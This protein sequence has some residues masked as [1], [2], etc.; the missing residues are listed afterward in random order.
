MNRQAWQE[1]TW[2]QYLPLLHRELAAPEIDSGL[3][4]SFV[5][6]DFQQTCAWWET[7]RYVFRSLLGW[8]CLPAGLAWWYEAGKPVLD[9]PRLRIVLERWDTR[10]EL[11]C[12][13]AREW[14]SGGYGSMFGQDLEWSVQDYE[15]SSGWLKEFQDRPPLMDHGPYG[16]G[17]NPL[18]LGHSDLLTV[19]KTTGPSTGS[20][21][22][23]TR[24]AIL[25]VRS[26]DS[27]QPELRAYG[28]TLPPMG[29]RSWHVEVFDRKVGYL[30]HFRQSRVTGLWFQG[31]H[32]IHMAGNPAPR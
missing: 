1:D 26:F 15:P 11:D 18:H 6:L 24:K 31:R 25:I 13:A 5:S 21:D 7:L 29:E 14:E 8:R 22:V 3:P 23:A 30:G 16:G 17:S 9:D 20:Y 4:R 12:F 27:W 19:S 2:L 10:R 28:S 32:S